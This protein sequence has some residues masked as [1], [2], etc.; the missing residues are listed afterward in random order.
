MW[1]SE[2]LQ[3]GYYY[4][5]LVSRVYSLNQLILLF[6]LFSLSGW[7]LETV[8]RSYQNRQFVNPGFL[9]GPILP[10]Y[11]LSGIFVLLTYICTM[12]V[13]II[14]RVLIYFSAIT[15]LEYI[16]GNVIYRLFKKRYWDYT[17]NRF[18]V[19]GH[20]CLPFS[21]I[22]TV[23]SL[24]G[25]ITIYPVSMKLLLIVPSPY[26]LIFNGLAIFVM[27]VDIMYSTGTLVKIWFIF[28]KILHAIESSPPFHAFSNVHLMLN[29][30]RY[31]LPFKRIH[32]L[33]N[34]YLKKMKWK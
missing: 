23:I 7:V 33:N 21:L 30:Q 19:G 28:I 10:I 13:F 29:P 1:L 4:I 6:F 27:Q 5:E 2:A 20:I 9:K 18:N 26:I 12:E 25:E 24:L 34:K 17:E 8:Y 31:L 3:R 14:Y 22:W 15:I 16:T 11:G 32:Q